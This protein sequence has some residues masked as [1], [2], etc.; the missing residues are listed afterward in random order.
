MDLGNLNS[1]LNT[2]H[3][4]VLR[5][6]RWLRTELRTSAASGGGIMDRSFKKKET[7]LLKQL[8]STAVSEMNPHLVTVNIKSPALYR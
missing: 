7:K 6:V 3:E 4:N 2:T 8:N 1:L 5:T